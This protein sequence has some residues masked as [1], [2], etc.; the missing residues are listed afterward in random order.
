MDKD[1]IITD[2]DKIKQVCEPVEDI[3]VEG[4]SIVDRLRSA[5]QESEMPG[6]GLAANQI[7]VNKRVFIMNLPED[8]CYYGYAFINPEVDEAGEAIDFDEGCLSFPGQTVKTR[9]CDRVIIKDALNKE[10]QTFV[11]L[12]A[13]VV[14]HEC[15][16][17]NGLTMFDRKK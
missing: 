4:M 10:G 15:D 17:L 13:V 3:I 9:R 14:Q 2:P 11:G 1:N 12:A 6:I 16:H 8:G 7:G 5:L